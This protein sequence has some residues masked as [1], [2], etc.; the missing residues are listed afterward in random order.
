M[1]SKPDRRADGKNRNEV[2]VDEER[3]LWQTT[4]RYISAFFWNPFLGGRVTRRSFRVHNQ[5][6]A[7]GAD[8]NNAYISPVAVGELPKVHMLAA[9][10]LCR[11]LK[12]TPN[13]REAV[14]PIPN[15]RNIGIVPPLLDSSSTS[16]RVSLIHS[17]EKYVDAKRERESALQDLKTSR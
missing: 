2:V 16:L 4:D 11:E 7:Y 13:A 12:I 15:D 6:A 8:S 1:T 14:C 5:G 3:K 17:P 10:L 9:Y